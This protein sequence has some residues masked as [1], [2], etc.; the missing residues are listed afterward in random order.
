[1]KT[2]LSR[3][4]TSLTLVGLMFSLCMSAWAG[5]RPRARTDD[6][7]VQAYSALANANHNYAGQRT[8]AMNHLKKA[9]DLLGIRMRGD[10]PDE[11][12]IRQG[13]SDEQVRAAYDMLREARLR[14]KGRPREEV[15]NAMDHI[16][17]ALDVK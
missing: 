11:Q 17:K 1:M 2:Q 14:L 15:E 13:N 4:I 5:P 3:S 9:G 10:S 8:A 16:A 7:L 12:H 6:L